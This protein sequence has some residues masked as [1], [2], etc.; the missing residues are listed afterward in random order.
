MLRAL[1][2]AFGAVVDQRF[3]GEQFGR[4]NSVGLR[5][6]LRPIHKGQD[7]AREDAVVVGQHGQLVLQVAF[8]LAD[9]A[10]QVVVGRRQRLRQA[11][12]QLIQL[13]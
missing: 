13:D 11:V 7:S 9:G 1:E 2:Q 4:L 8:A 5:R 3:D 12:P 6:G 10:D